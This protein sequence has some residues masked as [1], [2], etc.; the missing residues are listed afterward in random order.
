MSFEL[1]T[2]D[3]QQLTQ[4]TSNHLVEHTIDLLAKEQTLATVQQQLEDYQASESINAHRLLLICG[5]FIHYLTAHLERYGDWQKP[6]IEQLH[7]LIDPYL[8]HAEGERIDGLAKTTQKNL[9]N[10]AIAALKKQKKEG[11][12]D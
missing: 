11:K 10:K 3:I 1:F 9:L 6:N 8:S 7:Q 5:A 4:Q 2:R 12:M